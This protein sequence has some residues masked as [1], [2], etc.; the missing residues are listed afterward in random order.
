MHG[1]SAVAGI[2]LAITIGQFTTRVDDI[3][4]NTLYPAICA[5]KDRAD[6]LFE[7]FW[8]SNR[9]ALLWAA[10]MGCAGALFISDFVHLVIGEKWRFAAVLIGIVAGTAVVNQIGFNWTA[11]YRATGDTR[12]IGVLTTVNLVATLAIAVPLLATH[13]VTGFGVGLGVVTLIALA[14]RIG[15]L[16]RL[17][18][19]LQLASHVAHGVGP[20]LV[21]TGAVVVLRMAAG[22]PRTP[23]R[24]ALEGVLF[25][26]VGLATTYASERQLLKESLDYIRKRS[27][28]VPAP[29]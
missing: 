2:A 15:Y 17:F 18:P 14:I 28:P 5:V 29:A 11:F 22:G 25:G 4:T 10:P 27:T 12:P 20:A 24:V 8:K 7:A 16:L 13:G 9:L 21:A 1:P 3:V 19:A 23:G 6:L 26:V